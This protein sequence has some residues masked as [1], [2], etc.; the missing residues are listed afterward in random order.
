MGQIH[1]TLHVFVFFNIYIVSVFILLVN[2]YDRFKHT[3]IDYL[4]DLMSVYHNYPD[5]QMLSVCLFKAN[6]C[7]PILSTSFT[8]QT[9][10]RRK[11]LPNLVVHFVS[12]LHVLFTLYLI[13]LIMNTNDE[14]MKDKNE[15]C[16]WNMK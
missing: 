13:T 1:R 11:L 12:N 5:S 2:I 4:S 9:V 7:K 16:L 14:C 8:T 10:M 6:K 15:I 3:E